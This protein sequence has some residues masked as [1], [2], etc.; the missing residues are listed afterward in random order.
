M[1]VTR[2]AGSLMAVAVLLSAALLPR[3]AAADTDTDAHTVEIV[4]TGEKTSTS[5][6][7]ALVRELLKRLPVTIRWAFAPEIDPR[8]VLAPRMADSGLAARVWVDL[9]QRTGARLFVANAASDHFLVRLV[10]AEQGHE[11][12]EEEAVAQI[13]GSAVEAILAGGEIGVTREVAVRQIAVEPP[14]SVRTPSSP[15]PRS[16]SRDGISGSLGAFVGLRALGAGPLIGATPGFVG[17]I[18][19]PRRWAVQPRLALELQYDA[20]FDAQAQ[21][22]AVQFEGGGASLQ[23]GFQI[24]VGA[25]VALQASTGLGAEALHVRSHA[26]QG[27]AFVARG[28]FWAAAAVATVRVAVEVAVAGPISLFGSA[29]FDVDLS[30]VEFNVNDNGS[31][32][33]NVVPWRV[34]PIARLGASFSLEGAH[35]RAP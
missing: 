34:W 19:G 35:P 1:A 17:T 2:A 27:S 30:G 12:V 26:A 7:E 21:A 11:E 15:S 5:A 24:H 22:V 28:P 16:A 23:P 4:A 33:P 20:P 25:R 31:T 13:I 14:P 9:S 32:E 10:P 6:V 3:S 29:G 8:D 18:V